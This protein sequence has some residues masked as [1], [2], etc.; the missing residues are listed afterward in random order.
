MTKTLLLTFTG[1]ALGLLGSLVLSKAISSLLFGITA[2]DPITFG[3]M[4]L[5]LSVVALIA[6]YVPAR[7]A[8]RVELASVLRS[9]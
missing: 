4:A 2:T 5:A 3:G 6:G 1:V 9:S 7:R 8:S